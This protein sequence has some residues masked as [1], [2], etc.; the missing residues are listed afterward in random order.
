MLPCCW[1][2]QGRDWH[3]HQWL[4][5]LTAIDAVWHWLPRTMPHSWQLLSRLA[6]LICVAWPG[7][8]EHLHK[9][10]DTQLCVSFLQ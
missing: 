2:L 5:A 7:H 3:W 4:H 6:L 8:W 9:G 1:R 10:V